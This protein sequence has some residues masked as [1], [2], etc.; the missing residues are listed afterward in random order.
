M[1]RSAGRRKPAD[2]EASPAPIRGEEG[3]LIRRYRA[4]YPRLF[5]FLYGRAHSVARTK[6]LVLE[7]LERAG[8]AQAQGGADSRTLF[9]LARE[10]AARQAPRGGGREEGGMESDT[11]RAARACR[12]YDP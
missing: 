7:V 11:P 4:Y 2:G 5:A 1:A 12:R 9:A 10:V 3:S 6:A 8:S